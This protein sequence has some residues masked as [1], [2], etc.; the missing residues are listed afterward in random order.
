MSIP[1]IWE[2]SDA[3]LW[4]SFPK[5]R[6]MKKSREGVQDAQP[7]VHCLT[8]V[9][10]DV[11]LKVQDGLETETRGDDGLCSFMQGAFKWESRNQSGTPRKIVL[12]EGIV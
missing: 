1:P 3:L 11:R 6:G 7:T 4:A 12:S 10:W 8:T 5:P 9:Q 2:L